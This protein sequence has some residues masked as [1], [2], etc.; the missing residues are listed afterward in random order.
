MGRVSIQLEAWECE[1]FQM[2]VE[3]G[4]EQ[5]LGSWVVERNSK[6][7]TKAEGGRDVAA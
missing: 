6:G 4:V 7:Q 5:T 3:E 2:E 1:L